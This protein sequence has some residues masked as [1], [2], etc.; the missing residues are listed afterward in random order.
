MIKI[1]IKA[2]DVFGK[3][4]YIMTKQQKAYGIYVIFC[5]LLSS[6]LELVGVSAIVPLVTALVNPEQILDDNRVQ[7][8]MSKLGIEPDRQQMVVFIVIAVIVIY[9]LKN[10]FF[11]LNTYIQLKYAYKIQRECSESMFSSYVHRGFTFFLNHN[12]NELMQ[13]AAGDISGLYCIISDILQLFT[14]VSIIGLIVAYMIYTD[15]RIAVSVV[16]SAII[17]LAIITLFFKVKMREAGIHNT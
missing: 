2:K 11:I 17:C 4:S 9:I 14:Q 13:G 15:W 6:L 5:I 10:L 16:L 8:F 1:F 12:V 7:A 3:L